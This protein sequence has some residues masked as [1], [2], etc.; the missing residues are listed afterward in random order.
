V[1]RRHNNSSKTEPIIALVSEQE[2]GAFCIFADPFAMHRKNTRF[3]KERSLGMIS[4]KSMGAAIP[5]R[6][7]A[8]SQSGCAFIVGKVF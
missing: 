2:A 1:Q 6:G 4:A 5:M 7:V 3:Q 8:G